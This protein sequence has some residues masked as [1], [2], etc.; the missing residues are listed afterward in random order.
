MTEE[1]AASAEEVSASTQEQTAGLEEMSAGAQELAA[2]ADQM[3]EAVNT[4]VL[5]GAAEKQE[6]TQAA[7]RVVPLRRTSN[8]VDATPAASRSGRARR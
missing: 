4:F 3:Q 8:L 5:E 7:G 6:S 1:N 2:L